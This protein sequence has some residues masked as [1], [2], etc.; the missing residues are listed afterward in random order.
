MFF[1]KK[2]P[3]IFKLYWISGLAIFLSIIILNLYTYINNI[4]PHKTYSYKKHVSIG[5][6]EYREVNNLPIERDSHGRWINIFRSQKQYEFNNE[7]IYLLKEYKGEKINKD[8]VF[9]IS[10]LIEHNKIN[11]VENINSNNIFDFQLHPLP[12]F[13]NIDGEYHFL[14]TDPDGKDRLFLYT[15]SLFYTLKISLFSVC[16][17]LFFGLIIGIITSYYPQ[18]K[19]SKI[20]FFLNRMLESVP[21]LLW[22]LISIIIV[23]TIIPIQ[24]DK[25]QWHILFSLYGIFYSPSLTKIIQLQFSKLQKEDFIV[26]LKMNGFTN[27]YIIFSQIIRYYC[28]TSIFTQVSSV[29]GQA[30]YLDMTFAFID[31]LKNE[32]SIGYLFQRATIDF[33][34]YGPS[35]IIIIAG[36]TVSIIAFMR[37]NIILLNENE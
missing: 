32:N 2:I 29:I 13:T 33:T 34:N 27:Y 36:L 4:D 19:I 7:R 31:K 25:Y 1:L 9:Y 5:S 12:F 23:Q 6:V 14:G 8:R 35:G 15:N 26:S 21:I 24:Y 10:A 20:L 28:L 37:V 30:F 18:K 11:K 17:L 22:M 3:I 16:T